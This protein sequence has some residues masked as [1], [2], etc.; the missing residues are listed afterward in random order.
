MLLGGGRA[1]HVLAELYVGGLAKNR[2]EYQRI[3]AV[4]CLGKSEADIYA[5]DI[6]N[7]LPQ[8]HPADEICSEHTHFE[9]GGHGHAEL[10]AGG[11]NPI[12]GF[13]ARDNRLLNGT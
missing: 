9:S 10:F 4:G 6:Q 13:P 11:E 2:L 5:N 12:G 1:Q 3:L 7:T 8:L